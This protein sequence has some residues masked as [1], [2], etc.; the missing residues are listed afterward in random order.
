MSVLINF[1]ICDNAVECSGIEVCPTGALFWDEENKT[2]G[3]DNSKCTSCGTCE[4]S[5]PVNAIK[6]AKTDEEYEEIKKAIDE[7]PRKISDL[8]IE[9]YGAM[10]IH[11]DALISYDDLDK[12]IDIIKKSLLV[13]LFREDDLECLRRSIPI[14]EM[15]PGE[16]IVFRKVDVKNDVETSEKYA[17]SKFP[18]LIFLK[19]GKILGKVE[20]YFGEKDRDV[21]QNKINQMIGNE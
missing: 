7:D 19:E 9:R 14:R 3:I 11:P 1:K 12:E 5:C 17:V 6:V 2:I 21:F 8:F 20:G 16:D 18:C 4:S 10:P 15:I 13:E